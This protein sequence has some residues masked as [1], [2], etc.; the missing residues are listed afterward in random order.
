MG[1]GQWRTLVKDAGDRWEFFVHSTQLSYETIDKAAQKIK[2]FEM[3]YVATI[4]K[5]WFF[6]KEF[7]CE[8]AYKISKFG[9]GGGT[10]HIH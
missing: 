5:N 7:L 9:Y 3:K 8:D 6:L 1:C 2:S 4:V 10:P